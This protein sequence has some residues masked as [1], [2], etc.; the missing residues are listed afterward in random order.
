MNFAKK[1]KKP[2]IFLSTKSQQN[3]QKAMEKPFKPRVLSQHKRDEVARTTSLGKEISR[4]FESSLDKDSK[5]KTL[6]LG[7][8]SPNSSRFM[9]KAFVTLSLMSTSQVSVLPFIHF[10]AKKN[11]SFLRNGYFV[12]EKKINVLISLL[13]NVLS[14][15]SSRIGAWSNIGFGQM[16]WN[17]LL[18]V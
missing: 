17:K 13:A 15:P 12:K 3:F 9:Q 7:L 16:L 18:K 2:I 8:H 1:K 6:M 14:P 5:D 10:L 11:S 4:A